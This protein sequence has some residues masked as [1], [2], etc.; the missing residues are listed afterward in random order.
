[1]YRDVWQEA[2]RR[3]AISGVLSGEPEIGASRRIDYVALTRSA[4]V[5]EIRGGSEN[6]GAAGFSQWPLRNVRT[7]RAWP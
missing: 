2:Q 4:S 1:M 3:G 5:G 6:G 7:P